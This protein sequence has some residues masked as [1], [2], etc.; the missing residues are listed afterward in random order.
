MTL[1]NSVHTPLNARHGRVKQREMEMV[2]TRC[3]IH[4]HPNTWSANVTP[5]KI[6]RSAQC[7]TKST[8]S[9]DCQ[10]CHLILNNRTHVHRPHSKPLG[11]N[12]GPN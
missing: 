1:I 5:T 4:S 3:S 11:R 9:M 12:H 2:H 10:R 8:Y 6:S 7:S